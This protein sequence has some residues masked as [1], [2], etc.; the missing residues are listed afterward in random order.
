M[1]SKYIGYNQSDSHTPYAKFFSETIAV[2]SASVV[3][4][5]E[6]SALPSG[7]LAPFSQAA[8][9]QQPGYALVETGFTL[10]PDGSARV[11]VLTNMPGVAPLMWDWWFGW[12]GSHANRYKLWHPK[13]HQHAEWADGETELLAYVGR[14][15]IIEEYIGK[16]LEKGNIRFLSP[17][18]LGI[19]PNQTDCVWICARLGYTH[20]P[21]DLGWLVHQVRATEN[22]AEMRSRFWLGGSHIQLR[23]KGWLPKILS[24]LLQKTIR[25]QENQAKDLLRHCAEE[26]THLSAF[27]PELHSK[28]TKNNVEPTH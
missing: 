16:D 13:M 24:K 25:I 8:D 12:H 9:L 14:T 4:A 15:S 1:P 23:A 6:S 28:M 11:A 21:L 20:W 3:A 18:E 27:L 26:M 2:V 5:L 17:A 19:G 7:A 10:E 22:G